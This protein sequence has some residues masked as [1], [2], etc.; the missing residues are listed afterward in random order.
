MAIREKGGRWHWRFQVDGAAYSGATDL[1]ATE[2]NRT[3]ANRIEAKARELVL[4]GRATE[5]RVQVRLFSDAAVSFLNWAAGEYRAHPNSAKRLRTS[6][7]SLDEFFGPRPVSS[8]TAGT[9]EDYKAW[10]ATEHR[11]KDVTI[12]H[13]LHALSVFM[14]YAQKYAW[15]RHNPVR[16]VEIPSDADAVRM[17]VLSDAEEH[18]YFT[19][20]KRNQDL[21]DLGRLML[22]QGCRP[23]ELLGLEKKHVDLAGGFMRIVAGKSKA[24]RRRLRLVSE[25]R[26]ILAGRMGTAGQWVFPSRRTGGHIV[27]LNQAHDRVLELSATCH[28]GR[29]RADH[30]SDSKC[31]SFQERERLAFVMY[32][33]RHTFATRAAEDGMAPAALAAILGHGDLRSITKYV[34][35]R[36]DA[37]DRAMEQRDARASL[38]PV[39]ITAGSDIQRLSG[40]DRDGRKPQ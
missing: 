15:A 20:A 23:E 32:D 6:F 5:L 18:L 13:D 9:I 38:R 2:R 33:L 19:L 26:L 11:V 31:Q 22:N 29:I 36:Q 7:A 30:T 17:H 39:G 1:V 10:R 4:A 40:K 24:A 27:K 14:Q 35:V 37:M 25:S 3:A 34:H 21:Y 12:R 8:V 16:D 28:C